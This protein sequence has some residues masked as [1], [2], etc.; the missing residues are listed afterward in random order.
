MLIELLNNP[1]MQLMNVAV[2]VVF[3]STPSIE[4]LSRS[5]RTM[6]HLM[7]IKLIHF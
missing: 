2:N 6:F 7:S 4:V 5:Q 1:M 3:V